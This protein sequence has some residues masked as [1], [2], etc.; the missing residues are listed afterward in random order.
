MTKGQFQWPPKK[1]SSTKIA[2][3]FIYATIADVVN[4][5]LKIKPLKF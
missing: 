5:K 4:F 3:I 2:L 1:F